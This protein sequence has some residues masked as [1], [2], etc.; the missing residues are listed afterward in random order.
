MPRAVRFD[1]YGDVDVLHI[2]DVP[3]PEATPG[4]VVVRVI[5]AGLNPGEIPVR[6]G[7]FEEQWPTTFPS[8]Q[9]S[10]FAGIVEASAAGGFA[11]E[12][13]VLGWSD[14]RGAQADL[15]SVPADHLTAKPAEVPWEVAGALAVAGFTALSLRDAADAGPDDAVVVS[16][17]A[18]GVGVL[19]AQL[20]RR[21]GAR[22]IGL[23]SP[24][25]HELLRGL[26]VEPLDYHGDDLADRIRAAAPDGVTAVLDT[27][28]GG[29]V[30]LGIELGVPATRIATIIDFESAKRH[31]TTVTGQARTQSADNLAILAMLIAEGE[32]TVPIEA[33]YPL[34]EVRA[35][36]RALAERHA[37][38][39]IVLDVL[40]G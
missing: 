7:A 4:R 23:A 32:L 24:S 30:D 20:V 13:A 26:G 17:A 40:P 21:T 36:Y 38:G 22:V 19:A 10:D 6:E 11:V 27:H 18:G 15:V 33:R 14:E 12:D 29:Y 2:A 1:R 5:A 35:A 3:T 37:A 39:K 8:G 31:G 16:G 28:G 25:H 9:G 34:G